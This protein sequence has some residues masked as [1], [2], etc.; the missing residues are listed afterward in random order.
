M[1]LLLGMGALCAVSSV[2]EAVGELCSGLR[3]LLP[4]VAMF[5]IIA[6][7]ASFPLGAVLAGASYYHSKYVKK[8]KRMGGISKVGIAL[9]IMVAVGPGVIA[10]LSIILTVIA[11]PVLASIYGNGFVC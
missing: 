11:H 3:S 2:N 4:V 6:S 10:V 7:V 5:M 8:E 1:G 9:G